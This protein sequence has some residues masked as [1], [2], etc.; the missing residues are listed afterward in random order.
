MGAAGGNLLRDKIGERTIARFRKDASELYG[1]ANIAAP[2]VGY[3]RAVRNV[4][5]I[6]K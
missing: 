3:W 1:D 6:S 5:S 2:R 4:S